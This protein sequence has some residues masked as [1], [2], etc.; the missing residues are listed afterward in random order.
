MKKRLSII[1]LILSI[2]VLTISTIIIISFSNYVA[3]Y[4]PWYSFLT[5]EAAIAYLIV[6]SI[7]ALLSF[8][9]II[10]VP[11]KLIKMKKSEV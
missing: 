5:L 8:I 4:Q 9:T 2:I 3:T 10:I 6:A 1:V 7:L 11:I